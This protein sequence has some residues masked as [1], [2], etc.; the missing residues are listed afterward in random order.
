MA[1]GMTFSAQTAR[2][3]INVA[4]TDQNHCYVKA[5]ITVRAESTEK[6]TQIADMV[7]VHL[8]DSQNHMAILADKP[9]D[10][11]DYSIHIS[12]DISLPENTTLNLKTTHGNILCQNINGGIIAVTTHASITCSDING[13]MNLSTTHGKIELT[14]IIGNTKARTTHNQIKA[15][16]ITGNIDLNATHGKITCGQLI[17]QKLNIHTTHNNVDVSF[18]T[19]IKPDIEANIVTTHGSITLHMPEAFAGEVIMSTTHSKIKTDRPLTVMGEISQNHLAGT[20]G[21]G[22]GKLNLKTTHGKINLK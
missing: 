1:E 20:I 6:A 2:G 19:N 9:N 15:E 13:N 12:Y 5:N 22:N 14:D 18:S 7:K 8:E 4:G 17:S 16:R 10:S 21:Q 3:H 11:S